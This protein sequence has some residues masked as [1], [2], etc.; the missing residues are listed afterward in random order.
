MPWAS[1]TLTLIGSCNCFPTTCSWPFPDTRTMLLAIPEDAIAVKRTES[2]PV[3]TALTKFASVS[4][5]S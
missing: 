5:A 2:N 4:V 3:A 1:T